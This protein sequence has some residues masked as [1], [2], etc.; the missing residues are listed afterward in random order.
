MEVQKNY[1]VSQF[2]CGSQRYEIGAWQDI[3]TRTCQE[4]SMLVTERDGTVLAAV[5]DGMGG[6]G[7]GDVAS[8]TAV[9]LLFNL[10]MEESLADPSGFYEDSVDLLDAKVYFLEDENKNRL[11]AGTTIVSVILRE[12]LLHWLSVGDSRIY[13]LRESDLVQ[14]TRDHTYG[15]QLLDRLAQKRITQE[16]FDGE[17]KKHGS[18]T[19]F[20]G[21]GGIR[22]MDTPAAPLPL[23]PGDFV[24]LTSDGLYNAINMDDLTQ[25]G[26]KTVPEAMEI[27][28]RMIDECDLL[29]RDN[30]SFILIR[31]LAQD[32]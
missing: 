21:I 14:V 6:L 4:D 12:N 23:Y 7:G 13:V 8:R 24:L 18:L 19:S 20:L 27:I 9:D 15:E 31:C 1:G 30:T 25:I 32:E 16:Q 3:G 28:E 29:V 2:I 17:A 11:K 5:C 10:F 26:G 22:L